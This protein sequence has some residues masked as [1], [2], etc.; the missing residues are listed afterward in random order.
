MAKIESDFSN[1]NFNNLYPQ[2]GWALNSQNVKLIWLPIVRVLSNP[3]L[4]RTDNILSQEMKVSHNHEVDAF[5]ETLRKL[6]LA[7]RELSK[8]LRVAA[9]PLNDLNSV[10]IFNNKIEATNLIPLF[11]DITFIYLR[12]ISNDFTRA[13]RYVLFLHPESAPVEFKKLLGNAKNNKLDKMIPDVNRIRDIFTNLTNWYYI[14]N[15]RP[16]ENNKHKRGIRSS[17]EHHPISVSVHHSKVGDDPWKVNVDLGDPTRSEYWN[18]LTQIIR[19]I[20]AEMCIFW[21]EICKTVQ[22][23]NTYKLWIH[24]YGDELGG[25]IGDNDEKTHFWPKLKEKWGV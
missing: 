1:S 10:E 15:E 3:D 14:L 19:D 18:D 13:S 5:S 25:L 4:I 12:R 16:E 7:L 23:D 9:G 17:M 8:L 2:H 24:P 22:F 20:I 21:T 11:V 6:A